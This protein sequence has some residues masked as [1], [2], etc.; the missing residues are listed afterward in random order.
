MTP[1]PKK[2]QI[3]TTTTKSF[4]KQKHAEIEK[5]YISDFHELRV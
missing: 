4:N 5:Y 2:T 1:K 3:L